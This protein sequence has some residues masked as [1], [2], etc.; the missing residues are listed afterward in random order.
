MVI[1]SKYNGERASF[2]F[3]N[4]S[5]FLLYGVQILSEIDFNKTGITKYWYHRYGFSAA[6]LAVINS[7]DPN[8]AFRTYGSGADIIVFAYRNVTMLIVTTGFSAA[9]F[10]I[11]SFYEIQNKTMPWIIKPT[12]I[13]VIIATF[14]V[15]NILTII[16]VVNNDYS[17]VNMLLFWLFGLG[18]VYCIVFNYGFHTLRTV[19]SHYRS[20][21]G[22]DNDALNKGLQNM[23]RYQI[24]STTVVS[25]A[26][27][28]CLALGFN[29][30]RKTYSKPTPDKYSIDKALLMAVQA[31]IWISFLW[32]SWVPLRVPC[33]KREQS[34]HSPANSAQQ[35]PSLKPMKPKNS[36]APRSPSEADK[37]PSLILNAPA[38]VEGKKPSLVY[39]NSASTSNV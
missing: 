7:V 3:I 32:F 30:S 1:D 35:S 9:F 25:I 39:G 37:R 26:A 21:Q 36:L 33:A 16:Q 31:I 38:S 23:K 12:I 11:R 17:Y 20:N 6:V 8:E 10:S 18:I 5:L 2:L 34:F 15:N 4:C 27:I 22:G 19:V 29:N 13:F 14:V 28:V 24:I